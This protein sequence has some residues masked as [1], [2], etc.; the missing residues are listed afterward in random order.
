V[1]GGFFGERGGAGVEVRWLR[2]LWIDVVFVALLLSVGAAMDGETPRLR[3]EAAGLVVLFL[4]YL[5]ILVPLTFLILRSALAGWWLAA[6]AILAAGGA[7]LL[8]E[9]WE[10]LL[11]GASLGGVVRPLAIEGGLLVVGAVLI[12]VLARDWRRSPSRPGWRELVAAAPTAGALALAYALGYVAVAA[13][14][15]R[16]GTG[17]RGTASPGLGM[18]LA[19]GMGRGALMVA[20]AAPLVFTLFGRRVKN[21]A[22]VGALLAIAGGVVPHLAM[23]RGLSA[24]VVAGGVL[25]GVLGFLLGWGLVRF[26]RP[27]LVEVGSSGAR[28]AV[29]EEGST[30]EPAAS[31]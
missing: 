19:S 8:A 22:G 13:A 16:A 11:L 25:Q 23:A 14:L 9:G 12:V 10:R 21:A 31:P 28:P 5:A 6:A 26:T 30:E 3:P 4:S 24:A 7:R 1:C 27:P 18:L 20:C 29:Q 2:Q 17:Y 15:T